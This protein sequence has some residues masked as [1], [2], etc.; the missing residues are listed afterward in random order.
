MSSVKKADEIVRALSMVRVY[1]DE[2]GECPTL[3]EVYK[4]IQESHAEDA[5]S[6]DAI[7]IGF[8]VAMG[9]SELA[10]HNNIDPIVYRHYHVWLIS[11]DR[12]VRGAYDAPAGTWEDKA[13]YIGQRDSFDDAYHL[14]NDIANFCWDAELETDWNMEKLVPVI[15]GQPR[16]SFVHSSVLLTA[17]ATFSA[18]DAMEA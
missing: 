4:R 9:Q 18:T 13:V 11:R 3:D 8:H 1:L 5:P 10:A 15:V 6:Y 2:E 17:S 16:L 12:A 14:M 7:S